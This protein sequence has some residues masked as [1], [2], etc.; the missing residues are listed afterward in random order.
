MNLSGNLNVSNGQRTKVS[1]VGRP[2]GTLR[3]SSLTDLSLGKPPH[4]L[5]ETSH[6]FGGE[7][8]DFHNQCAC[9]V[10]GTLT[11]ELS[12]ELSVIS[13]RCNRKRMLFV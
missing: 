12:I 11:I 3:I 10:S 1:N 7:H 6:V 2:L 9:D 4:F 8:S 5:D 13:V